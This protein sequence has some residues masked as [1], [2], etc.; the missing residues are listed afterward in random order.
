MWRRSAHDILGT[1]SSR[2]RVLTPPPSSDNWERV[3][4]LFLAAVELPSA[5][6][7]AYLDEACAGQPALRAE[8]ESLLATE[9]KAEA[10]LSSAVAESAGWLLSEDA[11]PGAQVGVWRIE[12]EIGRG[13][14][15]TVYLG[16]RDDEH[17]RQQAAIKLVRRG[18]DTA[19]LLGRFRHERQILA[20]L[21][22]PYIARLIDGG[23]VP[24]GRPFLVME[25]V[26]GEPIDEYCRARN[27]SI[28]ERCR[29][30]LKVCEA[31]SYAHRNLV[32]HRDLKPGNI[33]ITAAGS[34]KLLDF[35]LAKILHPELDAGVTA[36]PHTR[37]FTPEYASPEQA[38]GAAVNTA[39]D[40]Y[41]LGAILYEL[42]SGVKAHQLE[43]VDRAQWLEII[44]QRQIA[45]PSAFRRHLAGD[46]DTIVLMAM[47]KEPG[48]RYSSVD[49]FAEDI[50][51]YLECR[52]VQARKDA[53]GYR[54]AKFVRRRRYPLAA[55]AVVLASL[56]S[57]IFLALSQARQAEAA[58]RVAEAQKRTAERDRVEAQMARKTAEAESAR[59]QERL[60]QM[61][62]LSNRALSDVYAL[63]ARLQGAIPARRKL[64]TTTLEFLENLSREARGD[65][66]LA[67]ALATAYLRLGDLQGDFDTINL[68]DPQ[69]ALK[70]YRAGAALLEPA[71][72]AGPER[73][74]LWVDL[75]Q[76][77]GKLLG[78]SG[79]LDGAARVLRH[80][81]ER[82]PSLLRAGDPDILRRRAGLYL[83]LSRTTSNRD[84]REAGIYAAQYLDA[85]GAM[86][87]RFPADAEIMHDLSIAHTQLGWVQ[88][89][90]GDLESTAVHYRQAVDLREQL[91][92]A[93][94]NDI[95][96]R[97]SLMLSYE[98][99]AALQ[100]S[101]QV[102]NLGQ[103]GVARQYYA[104]ARP[105]EEAAHADPQS[106][107]YDYANFLM[108][109]ALIEPPREELAASL[110]TLRQVAAMFEA[111][112]I[113]GPGLRN[114]RNLAIVFE[115]MGYRLQAMGNYAEA[116]AQFERSLAI[117]VRILAA[118]AEDRAALAQALNSERGIARSLM[119][120]G[121]RAGA[122]ER[123]GKLVARAEAGRKSARDRELRQSYAAD[124]WLTLAALHQACGETAKA[125][126]DAQ[127]SLAMARPLL[128]GRP[129]DPNARIVR[130]AQAILQPDIAGASPR[131]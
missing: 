29:L 82:S 49:H 16:S 1:L 101:P 86:H 120:A 26:E 62:N 112:S 67:T 117:A 116:F 35:G 55:A 56:V 113:G 83:S 123:A 30:F 33:L 80:A 9:A 95:Q 71:D 54:A 41:S 108:R 6:R 114:E 99:Y 22:H 4:E 130:E 129:R 68:G 58:R 50:R 127:Q 78:E 27:L 94:P 24:D 109:S 47:R 84:W 32:V 98:H 40:I 87:K 43:G 20:N 52:P 28:E 74:V 72:G 76:R 21:D 31:V 53:L 131:P 105:L 13:G 39:S 121:N 59:A 125:R 126:D 38:L 5:R 90:Q 61:V 64:V 60:S 70:S 3:Q 10:S 18:M 96:Y 46:L 12:R 75:E 100:G 88:M 124:A 111:P 69:G 42:L 14:M 15:G 45:R 11:A 66:R 23:N 25:Y 57:G 77:I 51:R 65:P 8:V 107:Q 37:P 104:K 102:A 79:D 91:V 7:A 85:I 122:L 63:M 48:R 103:P 34:P 128:T 93:H 89:G 115:Y 19:D 2:S 119:Q 36:L 118:D 73:L 44:C 106:S 81:L 92:K 17:F 97:R 110:A